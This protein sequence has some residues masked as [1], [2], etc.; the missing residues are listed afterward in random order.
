MKA[1]KILFFILNFLA[2]AGFGLS[3]YLPWWNDL[4]PK[5]AGL[6][7]ILPFTLPDQ[8][9]SLYPS[10]AGAILAG[11]VFLLVSSLFSLKFMTFIGLLINISIA[12]FWFASLGISFNFGGIG[13]GLYLAVGSAVLAAL[14]LFIRRRNGKRKRE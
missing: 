4:A 6:A 8:I 11:A 3:A 7:E 9:A 14:S 1:R 5:N 12:G 10:A 2:A 13:D